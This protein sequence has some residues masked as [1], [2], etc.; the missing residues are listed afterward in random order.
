MS[1]AG[2][3][4]YK[5]QKKSEVKLSYPRL[6]AAA[7]GLAV[8]LSACADFSGGVPLPAQTKAEAVPMPLGGGFAAAGGADRLLP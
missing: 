6:F 5:S 7:L 1:E 8:S 2:T 3:N 4:V